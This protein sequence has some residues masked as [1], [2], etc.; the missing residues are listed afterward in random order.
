MTTWAQKVYLMI[1]KSWQSYSWEKWNCVVSSTKVYWEI[2]QFLFYHSLINGR[3]CGGC[4]SHYTFPP[5]IPPALTF[6]LIQIFWIFKTLVK[7]HLLQVVPS[8]NY[9][10]PLS[11]DSKC[12]PSVSSDSLHS[13]LFPQDGQLTQGTEHFWFIFLPHPHYHPQC[14]GIWHTLAKPKSH[15]YILPRAGSM[16]VC[17][18]DVWPSWKNFGET[19]EN[20]QDQCEFSLNDSCSYHL[21]LWTCSTSA[22]MELVCLGGPRAGTRTGYTF[23]S[24]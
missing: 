6:L 17:W 15:Q 3:R 2:D 9:S 1:L 12:T 4:Y 19:L 10:L 22:N 21:L 16:S 5:G 8:Q 18:A 7:C 24:I 20:P 23:G 14:P 13:S 11:L